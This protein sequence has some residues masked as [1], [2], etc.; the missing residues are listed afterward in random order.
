MKQVI[1]NGQSYLAEKLVQGEGT[2]EV[3]NALATGPTVTKNDVANYMKAENLGELKTI[4]FGGAG[5]AFSEVALDKD[6][7]FAIKVAGLVMEEAKATA[8][9]KLVNSEFDAGLAG[10]SARPSNPDVWSS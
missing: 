9:D 4:S 5:V 1:V 2:L 10:A 8:V 6:I 3:V 7:V